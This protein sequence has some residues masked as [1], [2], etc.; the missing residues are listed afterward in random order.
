MATLNQADYNRIQEQIRNQFILEKDKAIQDIITTYYGSMRYIIERYLASQFSV[1]PT[2]SDDL[3]REILSAIS[4]TQGTMEGSFSRNLGAMFDNGVAL[5]LTPALFFDRNVAPF[6]SVIE[7]KKQQTLSNLLYKEGVSNLSISENI[8]NINY[9]TD[10]FKIIRDGMASGQSSF[11]IAESL[12]QYSISGDGFYNAYRLAYTEL[13]HANALSQIEAVRD[14][15]KEGDFK[16]LIEQY[17]SPMHRQYCICDILAGFYDPDKPVPKIPRHPNCNCGQRQYISTPELEKQVSSVSEKLREAE[18]GRDNQ[19]LLDLGVDP[20]KVLAKSQNKWNAQLEYIT[21]KLK[22]ADQQKA[23][24][25][26]ANTVDVNDPV[27]KTVSGILK[28]L[29]KVERQS[30]FALPSTSS[31]VSK[32]PNSISIK[33]T[34][35]DLTQKEIDFLNA[36]GVKILTKPVSALEMNSQGSYDVASNSLYVDIENFG[37]ESQKTFIHEMA[38][39]IDTNLGSIGK[40][41]GDRQFLSLSDEFS[42]LIVD[43]S[44]LTRDARYIILKRALGLQGEDG[45]KIQ[46]YIAAGTPYLEIPA[47]L[48]VM[49]T[50]FRSYFESPQELFAEGYMMYRTDPSFKEYAPALYN[51]YSTLNLNF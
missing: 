6:Q 40:K 35:L 27:G 51:Y 9:K 14:W 43:N 11:Q 3:I 12:E 39:A 33:G 21:Q 49:A 13:T 37:S 2:I 29:Y 8:W 18:F 46:R 7:P 38:H 34:K 17:L 28:N 24:Q 42:N 19:V 47:N 31:D 26:L 30:S 44:G 50:N 16:I 4:E 32:T 45:E 25:A 23:L 10:I 1:L 41:L 22:G 20:K 48:R 15:N 5:V 36:S